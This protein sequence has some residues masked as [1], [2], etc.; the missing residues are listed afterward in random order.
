MER[1]YSWW[2]GHDAALKLRR[3]ELAAAALE[4]PDDIELQAEIAEEIGRVLV[5]YRTHLTPIMVLFNT[6][7]LTPLQLAEYLVQPYPWL[8]VLTSMFE[9]LQEQFKRSGP[10]AAAA[11]PQ[12]APVG[13]PV[14]GRRHKYI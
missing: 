13:P 7:L 8:P 10:A 4:A 9:A 12:S 1:L 5:L 14:R 3:E 6:V 2:S 11:A